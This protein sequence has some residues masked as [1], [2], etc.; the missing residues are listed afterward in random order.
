MTGA[1]PFGQ[2]RDA[3]VR[4]SKGKVAWIGPRRR[5]AGRRRGQDV[6]HRRQGSDAGPRGP[7]HPHR[8][9]EEVLLDF[10]VL[11]EGRHALGSRGSRGRRRA[12]SAGPHEMIG[13][14]VRNAT[15]ALG[16]PPQ[17][18]VGL[19]GT[20]TRFW[21]AGSRPSS[22]A[23]RRTAWRHG[24]KGSVSPSSISAARARACGR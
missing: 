19:G 10:E 3:P 8:F 15:A 2:V 14:L 24:R 23:A 13:Y 18:I 6:E 7:A 16:H 1:Q 12:Q 22:M 11:S 9:D 5:C 17:P 21:S 20:D 4:V